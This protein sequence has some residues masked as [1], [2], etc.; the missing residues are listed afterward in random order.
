M[1]K[2]YNETKFK[3]FFFKIEKFCENHPPSR[4][5][6]HKVIDFAPSDA[7]QL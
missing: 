6:N 7:N 2:I 1:K 5:I 3:Y 4:H